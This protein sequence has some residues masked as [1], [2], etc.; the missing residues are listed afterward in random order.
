MA[1]AVSNAPLGSVG[2]G[3]GNQ[4]SGSDYRLQTAVF[5]EKLFDGKTG[6]N[7]LPC[8]RFFVRLGAGLFID[9]TRRYLYTAAHDRNVDLDRV[10]RF[11]APGD[12]Q[13]LK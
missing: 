3:T 9:L 6:K 7:V 4:K 11:G 8:R 13:I 12:S 10:E 2:T 1:S 5:I